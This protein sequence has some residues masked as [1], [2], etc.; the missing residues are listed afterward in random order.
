M[1]SRDRNDVF[2]NSDDFAA[3][4]ANVLDE[5]GDEESDSEQDDIIHEN[6]EMYDG[7]NDDSSDNESDENPPARPCDFAWSV[8][9]NTVSKMRFTG[10]HGINPIISRLLG[11]NCTESDVFN[12]FCDE[13][14]WAQPRIQLEE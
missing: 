6:N 3:Y 2:V 8:G 14:F 10:N 7:T 11:E 13:T 1:A 5:S 4:V 9:P 12:Y